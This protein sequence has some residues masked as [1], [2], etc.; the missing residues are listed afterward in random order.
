MGSW[1]YTYD[2]IGQLKSQTD[3]K[4]QTSTMVYDVLG[5]MTTR[6][7]PS[8]ISNFHYDK[9]ATGAAC[10][11]GIGKLCEATANNGYR[12]LNVY[13]GFGRSSKTST[14]IDSPTAP[15]DI[16]NTYDSSGRL[17]T[18]TYPA[19]TIG[20]NPTTRLIVKNN[21]NIYGYL[22]SIGNSGGTLSYW[23]ANAVDAEGH[24][25][26]ETLGKV[27]G[28][29]VGMQTTRTYNTATGRL[30]NIN[31]D[32]GV[33]QNM[34]FAYD[35]I[36][37][38]TARTD[39][40]TTPSAAT[41]NESYTYDVLN[42]LK[43]VVMSGTTNLGKSYSYDE[44]GNI[45]YKSDL[46][47]TGLYTYPASGASS[48]RPHAVTSVNGTIAGVVNPNYTYDANGNMI[49]AFGGTRQITY[50]SFNLPQKIMRG[51]TQ[52]TWLYDADHHRT[53]ETSNA[54]TAGQ[55]AS[56]I[57]VNPGNQPFFEKH[58]GIVGTGLTEYRHFI[59]G[60]AVYTQKSNAT[61]DTKYLLK[62]HLGSTT[63]VTNAAGSVI[64]RYSYDAFGKAR[65]LNGSDIASAAVMPTPSVRRGFTGHEMLPE[66]SGG[67]IHMNGRIYDPNLGRFMTADSVIPDADDSQSYNRYSYVFNNPL[68]MIDP[69]GHCPVC[70]VIIAVVGGAA[71]ST[72]TTI[73]M[74]VAMGAF[75]GAMAA[76]VASEGDP[77]AMLQ[78]A[79]IGGIMAGIGYAI[80]QGGAGAAGSAKSST[81]EPTLFASV[82]IH[83]FDGTFPTVIDGAQGTVTVTTKLVDLPAKSSMSAAGGATFAGTLASA[84]N[85]MAQAVT[86]GAASLNSALDYGR[87]GRYGWAVVYGTIG[88]LEVG[89]FIF[90]L[91]QSQ[92]LMV[93]M[94]TPVNMSRGLRHV[95]TN[96]ITKGEQV[97]E[98]VIRNAMKNAPLT[99]QQAG[100][101]SLPRVQRYVDKLL[102]GEVAPAI[103]VEGRMI[104]DGNHRYVAGRVLGQEPAIQPWVGGRPGNAVSWD[105]LPISPEAW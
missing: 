9:Y 42:R 36:G 46:G 57:Y 22:S 13:D 79:V 52:I 87:Q 63:V 4:L 93:G 27:S 34:A 49:T 80:S 53:K 33:R 14:Y 41:I 91:G 68:T 21:Y 32:S 28:G 94:R 62:D 78:G 10:N 77:R 102:K 31:T 95:G 76:A 37:N 64:E 16:D 45:T 20:A 50:E 92:A 48:V 7:E 25:T 89:A 60:V 88:A 65:N 6:N 104:V 29:F 23:T 55:A 51:A 19:V 2:A 35:G 5:R 15:Y 85:A 56:I 83:K 26:S 98:S 66:F 97:T 59:A 67:L 61:T 90:T 100:G 101:V 84:G 99:S 43:T 1:S 72:A 11:K 70:I 58:I 38:L 12:Q 8:L 24:V 40:F 103:K 44:I 71:V 75:F 17:S 74:A 96:A 18:V 82:D 69:D 73:G 54:G 39:V 47:G 30:T 3:A 86:P 81:S 105:K